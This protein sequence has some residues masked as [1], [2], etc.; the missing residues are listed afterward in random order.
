M[1]DK[2]YVS[3]T[4]REHMLV[5]PYM[6]IGP[7]EPAERFERLVRITNANKIEVYKN[8]VMISNAL[9]RIFLEILANSLDNIGE[10]REKGMYPVGTIDIDVYGDYISVKNYGNP[11]LIKRNLKEGIYNPQLIFGKL[12]VGSNFGDERKGAGM[13]GIGA[14]ATNV[15]S[16]EFT[17]IIEDSVNHLSYSQRWTNNMTNVTEPIITEYSGLTNSVNIIYRADMP[18]FGQSFFD[19]TSGGYTQE[20]IDLFTAHA[21]NASFAQSVIVNFN[22]IKLDY[23]A[24][25]SYAKLM[26]GYIEN[27]DKIIDRGIFY[28]EWPA[29][30]EI[31]H[32]R[33]G[34]EFTA[35]HK[36]IPNVQL[37]LLDTVGVSDNISFVN[38]IPTVNGGAHVTGAYEA[39][40]KTALDMVNEEVSKQ[41]DKYN[42]G[43][44]KKSVL[45]TMKHIKGH[46]SLIVSVKITNPAF[47]SQSKTELKSPKQTFKIPDKLIAK[48]KSWDL[49]EQLFI[50]VDRRT[51]A[52]MDKGTGRKQ[53]HLQLDIKE[54]DA[55]KAGTQMSDKCVLYLTEGKSGM[56]YANTFLSFVPTKRDFIGVMGMK[57]KGLNVMNANI[58]QIEANKEIRKL[59]TMIGL[60][61]GLDYTIPENKKKLRYGMLVIMA[62]ADVDGK[63]IIGLILN[64][65]HCRFPSLLIENFV[66]FYR[67]PIIRIT[68]ASTILKFYS[69]ESYGVW[70][71]ENKDTFKSWKHKYYKGLGSSREEEV[72]DDFKDPR[73][74]SCIYD[75]E[76]V[77][78]IELAFDKDLA[79][80]RKK[81]LSS[82]KSRTT[83]APV[84][85]EN[86]EYMP[87]S[88]FINHELIK[89]SKA[90]I[91][92][93]IP[94]LLDG[95]KECHRKSIF[96]AFEQWNISSGKYEEIKVAQFAP[97]ISFKS[98]YHHGEGILDDV[99][100]K[101]A[102]IYAGSN[103]VPLFDPA[104]QFGTRYEGGK[105]AA[106]SRYLFTKPSELFKY[107]FNPLDNNILIHREDEGHKVEPFYYFPIIPLIL[108]NGCKG[109]ATG[110]STFIPNF[111]I[112]DIID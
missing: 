101:M 91:I 85:K 83:P 59:K 33:N 67:T 30:A 76:S 100:T 84:F 58:F 21:V 13:N 61:E 63:H 50:E 80:M 22:K 56:P 37:V 97:F 73:F 31:I 42:K 89:F 32:K 112:V 79:D 72:E 74:V 107:I 9:E 66:M 44:D 41:L 11:I 14:K 52:L 77:K 34:N 55:N 5:R 12:L 75:E 69:E 38:C 29:G 106:A 17:V 23:I 46:I 111:N 62:D 6:Y 2:E 82:S 99:V 87:I 95:F 109:I 90:D 16:V 7:P 51:V 102:Q 68:H 48:I 25:Y 15:F 8:N 78:F 40:G 94:S 86:V 39:I 43:T 27:I 110:Y 53:K 60:D 28:Y 4:Q 70:K 47:D 71:E 20:M 36:V 93:S 92:R 19:G 35:D 108:V 49:I 96:G 103:N 26:F 10:T 81:W 45:L 104:G 65:F 64:Y 105:D 3:L 24:I 88:T 57:G 54:D 98:F 18:R 1:A